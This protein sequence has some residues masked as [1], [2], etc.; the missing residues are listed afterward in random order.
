MKRPENYAAWLQLRERMLVEDS[1]ERWCEEME[2]RV[3]LARI[4]S[5]MEKVA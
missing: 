4:P 1:V 3:F 5:R 2:D